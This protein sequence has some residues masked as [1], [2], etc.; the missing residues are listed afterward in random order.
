VAAARTAPDVKR[1]YVST[2]D[3]KIMAVAREVGADVIERPRELATDTSS[4]ESA[5]QHV[6]DQLGPDAQP[7]AVVFLQATSPFRRPGEVQRAI[8]HFRSETADSLFSG[9][10][11]HG[12][13]WR[14][15]MRGLEPLNYDPSR[16]PRRQDA[17]EDLIE[18]GSIYIFK[19]WVLHEFGSRLGG[20]IAV[21]RMDL[22]CSLQ[23]DE[24]EDLELMEILMAQDRYAEPAIRPRSGS[25]STVPA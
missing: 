11:T 4:S 17:P 19:P 12:F 21:Y 5:L 1:V 14:N 18:N 24:P 8:E 13:V 23:I 10:H 2:D 15:G 9:C 20:R 22:R 7:D 16:R 25:W 3:A 6:L